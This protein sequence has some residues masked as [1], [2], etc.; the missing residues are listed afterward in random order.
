MK[1][2][3]TRGEVPIRSVIVR[4]HEGRRI[5]SVTIATPFDRHPLVTL[6]ASVTPPAGLSQRVELFRARRALAD[7]APSVVE[8]SPETTREDEALD[9]G[10]VEIDWGKWCVTLLGMAPQVF[11]EAETVD[12]WEQ[13]E[14]HSVDY[15][16]PAN[17][18][19]YPG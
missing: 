4:A 19:G 15:V 8:L 7:F 3:V 17:E 6:A 9:A 14:R 2:S 11:A 1:I 13:F 18:G 12:S 16:P 10:L 5:Y